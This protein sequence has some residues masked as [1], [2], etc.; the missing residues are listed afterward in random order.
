[1]RPLRGP[2]ELSPLRG[3][4]IGVESDESDE[5]DRSDNQ[6]YKDIRA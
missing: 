5:S 6:E 1:M 3:S 2:N 4:G